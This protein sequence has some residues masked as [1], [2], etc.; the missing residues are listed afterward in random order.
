MVKVETKRFKDKKK[1]PEK[2]WVHGH[3][4]FKE[5]PACQGVTNE[6]SYGRGCRLRKR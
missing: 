2:F 3:E 4:H 6:H 1:E 5:C